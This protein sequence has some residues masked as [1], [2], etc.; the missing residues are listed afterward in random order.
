MTTLPNG[1]TQKT[2]V[3]NVALPTCSKTMSGLS[4]RISLTRL[5]KSPHHLEARLLLLGRLAAA[6]HH[7]GELVAVDEALRAE[8]LDQ[9]ALLVARD[10]ADAVGAGQRAELG[11]EHAE[12]AGGA[13]DEDL[14]AGL[15]VALVHEHPV[16]GEVRQ[17]VGRGLLPGEVLGLGEQ[18]L[19]L[20]LAELRERAPARLVAPD[21]LA[22][23][24]ERVEAVDLDVLVGGLVAVDDDLV[25]G[26]PARDA[27]PDLPDDP[28]GVR[29]ADV[30][31]LV[32]VVAEDRDRLAER[33][34][35]VVEVHAGRH[36]AHDDLERARA[37]GPRSPRAGTRRRARPRAPGG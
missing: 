32:R 33:R 29:A 9:R 37:R 1:L 2:L 22:R 18:L 34:P 15:Q 27:G 26:L 25:A 21:L 4:P 16:G 11:R 6:A 19:R 14:V 23:R 31:V 30:M 20:D 10:D 28:R 35:D 8:L 13:P 24:G 5:S 7:P 12:A 17:A 3:G 36:D